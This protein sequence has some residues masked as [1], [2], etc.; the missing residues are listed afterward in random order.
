VVHL[1][2]STHNWQVADIQIEAG[3]VQELFKMVIR[4]GL[5]R[6]QLIF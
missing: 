2:A 6:V 3:S 1:P 4:M 5:P